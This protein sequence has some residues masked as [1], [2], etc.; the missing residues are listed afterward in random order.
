MNQNNTFCVYRHIR[1]DTLMPFYIGIGIDL[2]RPYF[3]YGRNSDW[4]KIV[5]AVGYRVDIIFEDI[6]KEEA[7]SKEKELILLY[8]RIDRTTGI[9][10]NRNA[11]GQGGNRRI[12]TNYDRKNHPRPFKGRTHTEQ[13]KKSMSEKQKGRAVPVE[14]VEKMIATR[15]IIGWDMKQSTKD[16][17]SK[18]RTGYKNPIEEAIRHCEYKRKNR[19]ILKAYRPLSRSPNRGRF[20]IFQINPITGEIINTYNT[21]RAAGIALLI[22]D[23]NIHQCISGKRNLCG[24]FKWRKELKNG[25]PNIV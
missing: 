10:V 21:I 16:L 8:G 5:D 14:R 1:L 12:W 20:N 11:G 3:C 22:N 7:I 13:A 15:N 23:K 24:G 17:L 4:Q 18:V 9:L 6:S 19:P 25:S 2:K